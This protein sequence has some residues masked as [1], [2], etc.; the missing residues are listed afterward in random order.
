MN[1]KLRVRVTL[2]GN[3]PKFELMVDGLKICELS[4]SEIIDFIM[5]ATSSLRWEKPK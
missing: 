2:D 4:Y 1:D 3:F 5:Q